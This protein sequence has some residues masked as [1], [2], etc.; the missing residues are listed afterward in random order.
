[1]K[2]N[3]DL[4]ASA[5]VPYNFNEYNSIS[6]CLAAKPFVYF[7]FNPEFSLMINEHQN[8]KEVE[9]G[10]RFSIIVVRLN[11]NDR[12]FPFFV[13]TV[14]NE[15]FCWFF[16]SLEAFECWFGAIGGRKMFSL[17][18]KFH[19]TVPARFLSSFSLIIWYSQTVKKGRINSP[20]D[21]FLS[22]KRCKQKWVPSFEKIFKW[23]KNF[24]KENKTKFRHWSSYDLFWGHAGQQSLR[25]RHN[26]T[27]LSI[28]CVIMTSPPP[29]PPPVS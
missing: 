23:K 9:I 27:K 12:R 29:P 28:L 5:K 8:I 26:D 16:S 20:S 6:H 15:A 21:N 1:M 24:S 17:R 11:E 22:V 2:F 19:H 3:T 14:N 4:S 10:I 7:I 13:F 25:W 18:F